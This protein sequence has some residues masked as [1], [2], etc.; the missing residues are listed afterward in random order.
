METRARSQVSPRTVWTVGLNLL[1][2]G[3]VLGLLWLTRLVVAW[4]ALAL[5]LTVAL[6]PVMVWLERRGMKRPAAVLLVFGALGLSLLLF[7][8]SVVPLLVGQGREMADAL[9]ELLE[10]LRESRAAQWLDQR[11]GD[12]DVV[13]ERATQQATAAVGTAFTLARRALMGVLGLV[14]ILVLSMFMQLFGG[15]VVAGLLAWVRPDQRQQYLEIGRRMVHAVGGYMLGV[16]VV[17]SIGGTVTGATLLILGVPFFLPLALAAVVLGIIPFLG[18]WLVGVLIL[19]TTFATVGGRAALVALG[20]GLVYQQLEN[21]VLQ[22]LI[23][24]RTMRMNPLIISVVMLLGTN[25]LGVL[26]AILA[27]PFAG[28]LQVVLREVLLRR[29]TGWGEVLPRP[30]DE[31]PVQAELPM[32]PPRPA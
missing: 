2:L 7:A 28:A 32:G 1:M 18:A 31:R 11:V 27:L 15:E 30:H 4:L 10:R 16:L 14:T 21:H 26:G 23:Q 20:V 19:A 5:L 17:S 8:A 13:R 3:A 29:Q 25:L 9:P 12:I 6:Q 24:R 22:P